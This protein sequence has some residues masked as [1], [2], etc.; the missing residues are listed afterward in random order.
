M[1]LNNQTGKRMTDKQNKISKS[2]AKSFAYAFIGEIPKFIEAH[3]VE[4]I[5]W[6]AKN[7]LQDDTIKISNSEAD[8]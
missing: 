4:Y 3:K 1:T 5:S 6:L 8:K 7:G 2:Q